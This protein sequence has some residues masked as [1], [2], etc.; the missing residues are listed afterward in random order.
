MVAHVPRSTAGSPLRGRVLRGEP[1]IHPRGDDP[2]S[3][4]L[5]RL[6][7]PRRP[8]GGG[9][10]LLGPGDPVRAGRR[11]QPPGLRPFVP[12]ELPAVLEGIAHRRDPVQRGGVGDPSRPRRRRPAGLGLRG[13]HAHPD[14]RLPR[15]PAPVPLLRAPGRRGDR[16]PQ[17]R[18]ALLHGHV[19]GRGSGGR[20]HQPD[21]RRL[22]PVDHGVHRHDR[23]VRPG[24]L[25]ALALPA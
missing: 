14:L 4:R 6:R 8:R 23:R 20:R 5:G 22:L 25:T 18:R 13:E 10:A 24:T 12:A 2:G 11:E 9:R 21:L 3:R 19:D 16:D 7:P 17:R 1:R 15:E